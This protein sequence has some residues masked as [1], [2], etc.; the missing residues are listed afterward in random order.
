MQ[1]V[2][3]A[4]ARSGEVRTDSQ[5]LDL[6]LVQNDAFAFEMLLWRHGAL[7]LG[8]CE[9]VLGNAGEAEDA[10]QATF[11]VFVKKAAT[12]GR[13]E[14]VGSWLY[15]VAH[16][17]ASRLRTQLARRRIRSL[18]DYTLADAD[19][20]EAAARAA[21]RPEIISILDD[22]L[23][24][25]P[26]KY[27]DPVV[28]HFLQGRTCREV[29]R[30][31]GWPLGTVASR[32]GKARRLLHER[33]TRRG[34]IIPAALLFAPGFLTVE[35]RAAVIGNAARVALG[36][37][38]G[39]G[40]AAAPKILLLAE[41][42]CNAMAMKTWKL[43]A[44]SILA[45]LFF[46][47]LAWTLPT[48]QPIPP[49]VAEQRRAVDSQDWPR[50]GGT[51][52]RNMVQTAAKNLI[53]EADDATGKNIRW[54]AALG[55]RG[56]GGLALA[57][58]RIFVGTNNGHPR[59]PALKDDRGVMMCFDE[60]TG[61]FLWQATHARHPAGR[62]HD[63]PT[64]AIE[65]VPAIDDGRIYYLNNRCTL[66]CAR[67]EGKDGRADIVWEFDLMKELNV[68]PHAKSVSSPLI[69]GDLLVV[70]TGNGVDDS[71]VKVPAPL[72]PSFIALNKVTGKV[73][74]QDN[75][76]GA[77]ILH[78][79]W[80]S[81]A[82]GTIA[83]KPQ[84]VFPGGDGWLRGFE[85]TTGKLLWKFNCNPPEAH[86][87]LAQVGSRSEFLSAPVIHEG[88]VYI[89]VGQ[90]P[91]HVDG[92]GHFWCIDPARSAEL[93]DDRDISPHLV[94][95]AAANLP[96]TVVNPHSA[97]VWHYGGGPGKEQKQDR[98]FEFGRT[99]STCAIQDGLLYVAELGGYLHC[100]DARTGKRV[101][102]HDLRSSVWGS[103]LWA[104]GKIYVGT[105]DGELWVLRHGRVPAVLGRIELNGPIRSTPVVARDVVYVM[106][107][108][109][110]YALSAK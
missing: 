14:S 60:K 72:A 4:Q 102:V 90:D 63:G 62:I 27:R 100:L 59:D 71:H 32:L 64:D 10:F 46:G 8:V 109:T 11:L 29:A 18:D 22:E 16:R 31:L 56:A 20:M 15:K 69:V 1:Q 58:G 40:A 98:K 48:A 80:A 23:R 65:S 93:R 105:D 53:T 85:P 94:T 51:P 21:E 47:G 66:V 77:D 55:T 43:A 25:L 42:V 79:Q 84:V 52:A 7:V 68:F 75:S 3:R 12:I 95:N 61:K 36:Y 33:L 6:Y 108:S 74:W 81:P 28:L 26:A 103:A 70:V 44:T 106:T 86:R 50:F 87:R 13:R 67:A 92:D 41:G 88:C 76:P 45:V 35:A 110:L 96:I 5:L 34:I 2:R 19:K 57:D 78:G 83:G 9:R 17:T 89:G 104:D 107:N 30:D 54:R 82:Y 38:A 39:D 91:E 73:V 99:M 101:W 49:P 37:L 24:Q 97:C